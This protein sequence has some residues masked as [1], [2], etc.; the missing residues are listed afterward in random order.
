LGLR[1][2][3]PSVLKR[4]FWGAKQ[5]LRSRRGWTNGGEVEERTQRR[6]D[7]GIEGE[8]EGGI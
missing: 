7:V 3:R 1:F 8:I 4:A 2:F 6:I 5:I